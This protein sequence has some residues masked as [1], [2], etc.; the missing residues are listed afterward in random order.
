MIRYKY[1]LQFD[2]PAPFVLVTL[3]SPNGKEITGLPAQL[4]IA[5]DRSIIPEIVRDQLELIPLDE[6]KLVGF[7]GQVLTRKTFLIQIQI[8]D[9]PSLDIEVAADKEEPFVI[10]GRDV[11]NRFRILFDG[12]QLVF[13]I[14]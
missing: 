2:P 1:N 6:I 5:A 7:G 3:R 8:H 11:L 12:P 4:D 9:L 14:G 10:L 13:E